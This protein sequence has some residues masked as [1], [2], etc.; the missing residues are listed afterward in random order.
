MLES[1]I[2]NLKSPKGVAGRSA[3][4]QSLSSILDRRIRQP[5]DPG[6][7][8]DVAGRMKLGHHDGNQIFLGIDHEVGVVETAPV[9]PAD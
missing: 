2:L 6:V 8:V 3:T 7:N 4:P 1:E 5:D 9:K